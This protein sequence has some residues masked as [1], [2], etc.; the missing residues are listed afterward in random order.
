MT[1]K[2]M[3]RLYEQG[4]KRAR[5]EF[6]G[7]VEPIKPGWNPY[8]PWFPGYGMEWERGYN[9]TKMNRDK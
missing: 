5:D 7:Y 1:L 4:A 6:A 3:N 8:D 9:E 2:E